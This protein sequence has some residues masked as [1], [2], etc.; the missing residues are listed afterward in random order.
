MYIDICI[1]IFIYIVY[2][3]DQA[4]APNP[5][6]SLQPPSAPLAHPCHAC[7]SSSATPLQRD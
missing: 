2:D 6:P 1:I 3:H 4:L 5:A 7:S